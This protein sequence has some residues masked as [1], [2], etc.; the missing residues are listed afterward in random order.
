[1]GQLEKYGLYV[2][3]LVIFLILGVAI[4]GGDPQAGQG[5]GPLP[6]A[7]SSAPLP[8]PAGG[9][10]GNLVGGAGGGKP[11][12]AAVQSGSDAL[13]KLLSKGDLPKAPEAGKPAADAAR[14]GK[15]ADA[16]AT[17]PKPAPDTVRPRYKIKSGDTLEEI[18]I[19]QLGDRSH[20]D[21]IRKLNPGIDPR[22]LQ[23][24]QEL[25]LPSKAD[26]AG[27]GDAAAPPKAADASADKGADKGADKTAAGT[28]AWKWYRVVRGDT[29][30]GIS[31]KLFGG[32]TR[33]VEAIKQ[34]NPSLNPLRIR[35]GMEIKVPAQ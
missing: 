14:G 30:E 23:I 12:P 20:I 32:S 35:P 8:G 22:R 5:Q 2:L 9:P 6:L 3:C 25:T 21:A 24:N 4:W 13:S 29:Y 31:R 10:A 26:L 19:A 28:Q 11:T 16:A 17:P 15:P 27:A 7:G 1:M 34:L 18:A 33:Q